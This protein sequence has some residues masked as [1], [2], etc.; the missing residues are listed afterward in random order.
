MVCTEITL[1]LRYHTDENIKCKRIRNI[2]F[3]DAGIQNLLPDLEEKKT[4]LAGQKKKQN[5]DT[6]CT[7]IKV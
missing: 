4:I 7:G 2:F 5:N 6:K 1:I 3:T